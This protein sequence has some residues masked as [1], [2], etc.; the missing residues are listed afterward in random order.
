MKTE[1]CNKIKYDNEESALFVLKKLNQIKTK[2]KRPTRAYLCYCGSWHLTSR[3]DIKDIQ[4][5][6]SKLKL[7]ISKLK[8][9]ISKL[10]NQIRKKIHTS[11]D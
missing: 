2:K 8:Y 7:V 6:N 4:Q 9:T 1:N 10:K 11:K 5:E 3:P